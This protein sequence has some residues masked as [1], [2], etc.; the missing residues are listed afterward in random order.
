MFITIGYDK[1]G[2]EHILAADRN[3]HHTVD[4]RCGCNP[5]A[6]NTENPYGDSPTTGVWQWNHHAFEDEKRISWTTTP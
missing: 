2:D 5:D 6:F 3:L 4:S 1:E